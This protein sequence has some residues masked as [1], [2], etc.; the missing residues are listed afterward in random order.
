MTRCASVSTGW[1]RSRQTPG[2][3][4]GLSLVDAVASLHGGT[5]ALEDNKPGLRAAVTFTA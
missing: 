5:F 4:L 2:H 3:G 1:D